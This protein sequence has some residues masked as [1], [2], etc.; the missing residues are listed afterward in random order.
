M[1]QDTCMKGFPWIYTLRPSAREASQLGAL[2]PESWS[3][4]RGAPRPGWSTCGLSRKAWEKA[5]L[6]YTSLRASGELGTFP[7]SYSVPR[8][9][10]AVKE[11]VA[12]KEDVE[13]G[14]G[15]GKKGLQNKHNI[16]FPPTAF[17]C[18]RNSRPR[19]NLSGCRVWTRLKAYRSLPQ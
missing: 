11:V 3:R 2:T 19:H 6:T 1:L 10:W 9:R 13:R 16:A 14:W 12:G 5:A 18:I 8:T 7:D 15:Q 17:H 4:E